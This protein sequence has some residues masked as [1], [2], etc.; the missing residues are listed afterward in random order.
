MARFEAQVWV[1]GQHPYQAE[2]NAANVF[3]ARKN[4][5]RREGVDEKYV[6]RVFQVQEQTSSSSSSS[7]SLFSSGE[8]SSGGWLVGGLVLIGA[9]VTW[10]YYVIPAA[11]ILGVLWYFGTR[12]D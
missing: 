12:E 10:W 5:A 3:Q 2:I 4:I 1:S 9:I 6:N 11:I 7:S 8:S